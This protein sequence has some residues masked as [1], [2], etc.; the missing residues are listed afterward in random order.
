LT[1]IFNLSFQWR[2]LLR[3]RN[4][5]L[6]LGF[7]QLAVR[8]QLSRSFG[9]SGSLSDGSGFEKEMEKRLAFHLNFILINLEIV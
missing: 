2:H 9:T 7:H 6:G 4:R 3:F 8:L 5:K 1:F